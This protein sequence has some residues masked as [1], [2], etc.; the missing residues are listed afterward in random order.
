MNVA[1]GSSAE[2]VPAVELASTLL[3]DGGLVLAQSDGGPLLVASATSIAGLEGLR[4]VASGSSASVWLAPDRARVE[5]SLGLSS[6]DKGP[7]D[8]VNA[9]APTPALA[10][11]GLRVL[12][13]LLGGPAVFAIAMSEV[14]V[15]RARRLIGVGPGAID[16]DRCVWVRV[17]GSAGGSGG[18]AG[19]TPSERLLARARGPL[20]CTDV[21][22]PQG[23]VI[24]EFSHAVVRLAELGIVLEPGATLESAGAAA[25]VA[26]SVIGL[27]GSSGISVLRAGAYEERF[28]RKQAGLTVLFV[29]TGNTC[30]SPMASAIALGLRAEHVRIMSAG[31]STGGG[32]PATREAIDAVRR[33]GMP[34][35]NHQSTSLSRTMLEDADHV[36]VMTRS[37]LAHARAFADEATGLA[38]KVQLLDPGGSDV[39]DPV[40]M[41][42]ETYDF[43]AQRLRS[44]IE[45][46]WRE[47]GLIGPGPKDGAKQEHSS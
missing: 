8:P 18:S 5:R 6:G 35:P 47:L 29:C 46:R 16:D 7:G 34:M 10:G 12:R 3:A 21:Y 37:H 22:D 41:S 11:P 40:G 36:F 1:H 31:T 23:R 24:L 9:P 28:I 44:L 20:A 13:R 19:A 42:Q 25:R 38:G 15:D 17:P 45:A 39:P 14:H 32:E 26:A 4:R 2:S 43:T 27:D 30:R 33:M